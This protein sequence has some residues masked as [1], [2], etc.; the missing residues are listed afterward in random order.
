VKK[1]YV[2]MQFDSMTTV[3]TLLEGNYDKSMKIPG[4]R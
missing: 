1:K 3:P 2:S 4:I